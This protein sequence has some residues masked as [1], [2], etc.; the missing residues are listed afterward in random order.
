MSE[1]EE[2]KMNDKDFSAV[3]DEVFGQQ[4]NFA[5]NF[6]IMKMLSAFCTSY[7]IV[8]MELFKEIGETNFIKLLTETPHIQFAEEFLVAL[9]NA[10]KEVSLKEK[11]KGT[12]Q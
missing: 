2:I 4:S 5:R 8:R 12:V 3:L 6:A 11:E 9:G 1:I 7:S 10:L